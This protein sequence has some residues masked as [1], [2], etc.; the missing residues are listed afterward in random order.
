MTHMVK[1]ALILDLDNTLYSWIDSFAPSFRAQVHVLAKGLGVSE[2]ELVADF[3]EIYNA[4]GTV[5]YPQAVEDLRLWTRYEVAEKF[6]L[7]LIARAGKVFSI[8]YRRNLKLYPHVAEVLE[9]AKEQ[10]ISIIGL[11]DAL[12]HWAC[13]RLRSLGIERHFHGLYT[14]HR[15]W[16]NNRRTIKSPIRRRVQLSG[17]EL[18]PNVDAI[19]RVIRDFAV[20]RGTS[21]MV[22]DSLAK[23]IVVAQRAG[24]NDVWARY[25]TEPKAEN[26]ATIRRITP[27]TPSQQAEE[28]IARS[29]VTPTFVIDDFA[30]IQSLIGLSQ[31]ALF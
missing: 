20:D 8:V 13:F 26:R 9:W 3:Q 22:G 27:W 17:T 2:E 5:E 7:D 11:S 29:I 6:R 14:W 10:G 23:D 28:V 18:K 19:E 30:E 31:L 12:E 1:R 15:E 25:G 21:F 24:L 4:H 16:F